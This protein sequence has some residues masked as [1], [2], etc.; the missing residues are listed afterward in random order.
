[1]NLQLDGKRALVTGA[2]SGIGEAIARQ[3]A[4]E[5]A[6]VI[7]HGRDVKRASDVA[8]RI[9]KEGGRAEVLIGSLSST[10]EATAV[11]SNALA[12]GP[13]D[14]LINNA[15]GR[16]GSQ[17]VDLTDLRPAEWQQTYELNALTPLTLATHVLSGM[18]ERNWGRIIQ[19]GSIASWFVR[20]D[21]SDYG[22]AKIAL[23]YLTVALSKAIAGAA[24]TVNTVSPGAIATPALLSVL[25]QQAEQHGWVGSA[26]DIERAGVARRWPCTTGRLGRPDE[27]AALVA[28][29]ASPLAGF[30]NGANIRIDGGR[31]VL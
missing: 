10:A 16:P 28:F 26:D 11:A 24:V 5:G 14:I 18:R 31:A 27:V 15:G 4:Q 19:I 1:V 6:V 23:N 9:E 22:A 25:A 13:V 7:V 29:L 2:S 30:I 12:G 21:N 8:Q 20:P 3:L 17:P